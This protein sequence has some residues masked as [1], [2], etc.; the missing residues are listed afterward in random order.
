MAF[1]SFQTAQ[2][3][4]EALQEFAP[5]VFT[6]TPAPTDGGPDAATPDPVTA[7]AYSVL[8]DYNYKQIG[9]QP[10]SLIRAGD[11]NLLVAA[12]DVNGL[13]MPEPPP[14]SECVAADGVTYIVK[15]CK[16][17]APAGVAVLYDVQ[18]RK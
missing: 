8:L 14:E 15:N 4:L 2:D 5:S 17:L 7:S 11:K 9:T 6:W 3:A 16:P 12:I 18:L 13:A 1:D 10:D